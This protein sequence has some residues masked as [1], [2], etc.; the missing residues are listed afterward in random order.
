MKTCDNFKLL[1]STL[2]ALAH[3][4]YLRKCSLPL[5]SKERRAKLLERKITKANVTVLCIAGHSRDRR[6]SPILRQSLFTIITCIIL[7][8]GAVWG[9]KGEGNWR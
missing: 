9:K 8:F 5:E 3:K 2:W 1:I 4:I 6:K 7:T